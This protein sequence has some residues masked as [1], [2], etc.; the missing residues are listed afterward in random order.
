MKF[1]LD[2]H[3]LLFWL[4]DDDRLGPKARELIA[5]PV[6]DVLVSWASLWEIVVKMRVGRLAADIGEVLDATEGSGFLWL[7]IEPAHLV[8]LAALPT[9]HRDPFDHLLIAQAIAE[10]A[11]FIS[12]DANA[13]RYPL[14]I[15]SCSGRTR[16][17]S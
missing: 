16:R 7:A 14:E 12:A 15:V 11:A 8:T 2:T 9:H 5:D 1:L 13:R 3:A 17:R 6:N 10:K 4:N